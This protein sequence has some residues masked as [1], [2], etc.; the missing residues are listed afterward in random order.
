MINTSKGE[1][2]LINLFRR[3]GIKFER[4]VSFEDLHGKGKTLLRFDFALYQ[5]GKLVCLVEFDGK[6]HFEYTP[7]FHKNVSA[8][9]K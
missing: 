1:E 5:R 9:K 7:F 8:F 4:E 3:G 2:K 6:Q